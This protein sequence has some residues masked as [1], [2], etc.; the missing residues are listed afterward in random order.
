MHKRRVVVTGM[1]I[2]SPVGNT[3]D[4]AWANITAG[5]SGLGPITNFDASQ[6]ATRIAGQV[7]DFDATQWI[8]PKDAKKMDIFIHYGVAAAF[9]AMDD[10]GIEVTEAN[11]ERIGA[12]IGSG[13]GG[14]LGIEE[15]TARYLE[16]GP[17]N[18]AGS[19]VCR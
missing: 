14:I 13:I 10:S 4:S 16:G 6:F 1:G 3:L 5:R 15:Q 17:R 11:A 7:K 12:M 19:R 2:V 18:C 9:M 8:S